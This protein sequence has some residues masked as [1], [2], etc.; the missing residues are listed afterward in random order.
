ML[1]WHDMDPLEEGVLT[2]DPSLPETM[3]GGI[4]VAQE[5]WPGI[6]FP[7]GP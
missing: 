6:P 4:W 2:W 5:L 7:K 3:C 1:S